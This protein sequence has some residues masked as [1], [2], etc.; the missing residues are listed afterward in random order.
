MNETNST[1]TNP[2]TLSFNVA[3]FVSTAIITFFSSNIDDFV[4]LM[5]FFTLA[6]IRGS[7]LKSAHIFIGQY[8]GFITLLSLSLIAFGLARAVPVEL[9]GFLG[10]LPI[11][12]GLKS[13][14]ELIYEDDAQRELSNILPVMEISA[15]ELQSVRPRNSMSSVE[16][17]NDTSQTTE[18]QMQIMDRCRQ[19]LHA[20]KTALFSLQ[21][22]KVASI[23]LANGSDNIAIYSALFAQAQKWQIGI[24]IASYLFFVLL[25][26]LF[27]YF[28][29]NFRPILNIVQ[30]YAH[31]VVPFA[32]IGIG[33][34]I[35]ITSDCFP[36]LARAIRTKNF[37]NG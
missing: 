26:L 23:T 33:I 4:I 35:I 1:S 8:V 37:R 29:I 12:L 28:F 15:V 34:Y 30:K 20:F 13:L 17:D 3:Q 2:S 10:F 22:F 9:L 6:S 16:V 24:Y 18:N 19:L 36:W 27:C 32:F 31:Y 21:I 25:L 14:Y 11:V 7:A 5:N